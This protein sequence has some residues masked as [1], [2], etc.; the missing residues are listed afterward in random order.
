[1]N[2]KRL[3]AWNVRRLRV[4]KGLTQEALALSADVDMSHLANLEIE[5]ANPTVELLELIAN[6]LGSHISELFR[7]FPEDAK[8]PGPLK[9][10]R[11]PTSISRS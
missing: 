3:V 8:K 6:A 4:E 9:K 5:R 1:M 10:G 11:K 2:A 7:P